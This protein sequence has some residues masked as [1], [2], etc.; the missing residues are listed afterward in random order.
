M[1]G[2]AS[3]ACGTDS[4]L[5]AE[6]LNLKPRIIGKAVDMIIVEHVSGL[7]A[8]IF[9]KGAA[10][11]RYVGMTPYVGKRQ[12]LELRTEYFPYL[13]QLVRVVCCEYYFHVS[14]LF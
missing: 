4:R 8:G 6:G 13:P 10:S 11:L 9:L 7:L 2:S 1:A 5:T 3:I 14:S 12:Y